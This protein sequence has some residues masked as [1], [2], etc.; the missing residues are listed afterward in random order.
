[1]TGAEWLEKVRSMKKIEFIRWEVK[2]DYLDPD[3]AYMVIKADGHLIKL[4]VC[5]AEDLNGNEVIRSHSKDWMQVVSICLVINKLLEQLQIP[6]R[7]NVS[8]MNGNNLSKAIN[9]AVKLTKNEGK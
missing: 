4:E 6:E 1:M 3:V 7:F 8:I 2:G 9:T 5:H